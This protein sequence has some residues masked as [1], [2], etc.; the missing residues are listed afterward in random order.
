MKNEYEKRWGGLWWW[1]SCGGS[2]IG[3]GAGCVVVVVGGGGSSIQ[4]PSES[5]KY[6]KTKEG[7]ENENEQ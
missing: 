5:K 7:N 2:S 6:M 3:G 4:R 1:W